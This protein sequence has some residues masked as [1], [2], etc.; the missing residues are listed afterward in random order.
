[1]PGDPAQCRLYAERFALEHQISACF[2]SR[3]TLQVVSQLATVM[4]Q[5]STSVSSER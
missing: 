1:M 4:A 5:A 2:S 3:R